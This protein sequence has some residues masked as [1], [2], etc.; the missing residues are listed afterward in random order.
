MCAPRFTHRAAWP[1]TAALALACG[2]SL[3]PA[4]V[5]GNY[6]LQQIAGDP[7]PALG[8]ANEELVVRVFADTLRV[9]ADGRGTLVRVDE[10]EFPSDGTQVPPRRS[11]ISFSFRT[12]DDRVEIAFDCPINANCAP[13]PHR[14][15]RR[16]GGGLRVDYAPGTR[17]PMIY[18]RVAPSASPF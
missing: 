17:V 12:V 18:A 9:G 15:A 7:L 11:E 3:A 4:D 14:I 2:D 13:P 16:I 5:A 6:A 1:L 10:V 8:F